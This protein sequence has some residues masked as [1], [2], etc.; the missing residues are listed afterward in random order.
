MVEQA[1][2]DSARFALGSVV[3]VAGVA[4][5]VV[6]SKRSGGRLVVRLDRPVPR[7]S[8]LEVARSSLP[9][10]EPDSYYVADLVGLAVEEEHGRALGAVVQVDPGLANDVLE[11]DSGVR[12]PLIEDCVLE[13]DLERGR[14]V[15][16]AGFADPEGIARAADPEVGAPPRRPSQ[17]G[18]SE[19]SLGPGDDRPG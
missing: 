14:V 9:V 6:E 19:T 3:H 8:T 4:A 12:L 1:S 11:L 5:K 13:V 10:P 15:V 18:R 17:P 7:G 2:E 16:A